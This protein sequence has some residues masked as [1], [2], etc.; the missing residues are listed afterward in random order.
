M[1]TENEF[2]KQIYI[3]LIIIYPKIFFMKKTYFFVATII[4]VL[5]MSCYKDNSSLPSDLYNFNSAVHEFSFEYNG[6]KYSLTKAE[7]SVIR[8]NDNQITAMS[9]YKLDLFNGQIFYNP[10]C[11][12]AFMQPLTGEVIDTSDCALKY[13]DGS[14]ID[15]MEVYIYKSGIF[16]AKVSNQRQVKV[17]DII[18]NSYGDGWR[19]ETIRD[20]TGTFELIIANGKARKLL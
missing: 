15:S 9:I 5:L 12:L 7:W 10:G 3:L 8:N 16:D 19:Y 13:A 4:S 1:C 17:L 2:R 14:A 6:K 11:P 18:S 20:V